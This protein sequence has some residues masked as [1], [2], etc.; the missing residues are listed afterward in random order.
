MLA[1]DSSATTQELAA[2]MEE[3]SSSTKNIVNSVSDAKNNSGS[4]YNLA[5]EGENNSKEVQKR[6]EKMEQISR[7]SS[8]KTSRVYEDMKSRSDTAIEQSKAVK[9]INELTDDIKAISSQTNLLALNA[10]IEAARAG[11]AG[12]GFAVVATEIGQLASQT[13]STV[14]NINEIVD[15]VNQSVAGMTEC[16][17][18]IMDFLENTVLEDY[19]EFLE[20]GREY[21]TDADSFQNVMER[22]AD[23]IESLE[24]HIAHVMEASDEIDSMVSQSAD[25]I[26][27]IAEKSGSTQ[28]I[29]AEGYE[30]LKECRNAVEK[31]SAIVARFTV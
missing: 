24:K 30:K 1:A 19:S 12:R 25:G 9:R 14:E 11:D 16:I 3:A 26:Y 18:L 29:T 7:E 31:L 20:A 23:A 10:S 21:R 6:A 28:A 2:G 5:M 22:V 17:E 4:I 13:F 15:E 8:E 27:A